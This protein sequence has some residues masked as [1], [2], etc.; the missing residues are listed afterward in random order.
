M[1]KHTPRRGDAAPLSGGA[2]ERHETE[3]ERPRRPWPTGGMTQRGVGAQ[4]ES[5]LLAEEG[6][7]RTL[8]YAGS[9]AARGAADAVGLQ[10]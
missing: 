9:R 2:D 3:R 10:S 5:D 4:G 7:G 6:N 1:S 8:G